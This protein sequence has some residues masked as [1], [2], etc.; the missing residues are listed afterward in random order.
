MLT[1]EYFRKFKYDTQHIINFN[2]LFNDM[3]LFQTTIRNH[4]H[5]FFEN[6]PHG[7]IHTLGMFKFYHM[8]LSTLK[9]NVNT[10]YTVILYI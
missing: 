8:I 3:L 2:L 4:Y 1:V 7:S 10:K 5:N 6:V 9:N